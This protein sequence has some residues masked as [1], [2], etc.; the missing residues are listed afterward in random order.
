MQPYVISRIGDLL[1]V[2]ADRR[3]A[4]VR[5]ILYTLA[6]Y[7]LTVA[8]PANPSSLEMILWTDDGRKRV[9]IFGT[10]RPDKPVLTLE[11]DAGAPEPPPPDSGS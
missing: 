2:P 6:A 7:E 9:S 8:L 3:A 4:C 10:E 1:S 11:L 5:E